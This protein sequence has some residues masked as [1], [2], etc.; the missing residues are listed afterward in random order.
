MSNHLSNHN[1]RP[2]VNCTPNISLNLACATV[3]SVVRFAR[4]LTCPTP[5]GIYGLTSFGSSSSSSFID[6][7][8]RFKSSCSGIKLVR[9]ICGMGEGGGGGG[10]GASGIAV[11]LR[12]GFD[13]CRRDTRFRS[14]ASF[15]RL[16]SRSS[17]SACLFRSDAASSSCLL[18]SCSF[19]SC[20][21]LRADAASARCRLRSFSAACRFRSASNRR[22]S[23]R[24]TRSSASSCSLTRWEFCDMMRAAMSSSSSSRLPLPLVVS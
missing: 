11:D 15:N 17:L 4:R 16:R 13:C 6:S 9:D 24:A 23:S 22:D 1:D 2:P 19:S 12:I 5:D 20:C 14:A 18:R 7:R 10:G 21:L 8:L 3:S